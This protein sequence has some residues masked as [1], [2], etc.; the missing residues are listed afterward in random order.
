MSSF[1]FWLESEHIPQ[2]SLTFDTTRQKYR[3]RGEGSGVVWF[4]IYLCIFLFHSLFLLGL[5][6]NVG[7]IYTN[8]QIVLIFV[9]V[10]AKSMPTE[11]TKTTTHTNTHFLVC[12][13]TTIY[14]KDKRG[15]VLQL[16]TKPDIE[17]SSVLFV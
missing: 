3:W 8:G 17:C 13:C 4:I 9:F 14:T 11:K 16:V 6:N 7:S 2:M 5:I 10:F 1:L 12:T 15:W